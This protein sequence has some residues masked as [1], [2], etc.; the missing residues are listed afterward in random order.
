MAV[1]ISNTSTGSGNPSASSGVVTMSVNRASGEGLLLGI[2]YEYQWGAAD[3]ISSVVWDAAGDNQAFT[4]VLTNQLEVHNKYLAIYYL[5]APSSVKT[6]DVTV[7]FAGSTNDNWAG[8]CRH[9]TGHD[10]SAM[11]STSAQRDESTPETNDLPITIASAAGELVVA[12]C[13]IRIETTALSA[14]DAS[15]Y[16]E[17]VTAF[18]SRSIISGSKA[19]ASSVTITFGFDDSAFQA[20][21]LGA[22]SIAPS[23]GGSA[24]ITLTDPVSVVTGSTA[25]CTI[26]RSTAASGTITYNLTSSATGVATVPATATIADGQTTGTFNITG[27]SAGSSTITATNASDSGETDTATANVSALKGLEVTF[28]QANLSGLTFAWFDEASPDLFDA[29]TVVGTTESTDGSGV[30]SI[31]LTGTSVA[32]GN[33]GF[34]LIYKAGATAPDDIAFF[35]RMT[36]ADIG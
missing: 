25:A 11:V 30:M 13:G 3:A 33:T 34:L 35:G 17:L 31:N 19:G 7:T 10:T 26:T 14:G 12:F 5:A 18:S 28:G 4:H 8:M 24:T 15:D 29:P 2:F 22:V 23:G 32:V 20:N 16:Q 1:V 36:V 9:I 27:V 21:A 6:A